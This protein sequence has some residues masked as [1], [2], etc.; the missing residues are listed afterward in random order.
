MCK[1]E[2]ETLPYLGRKEVHNGDS[3][4]HVVPDTRLIDQDSNDLR[5]SQ[6]ENKVYIADFF[7]TS[8]PSICPKVTKQML[9]IYDKYKDDDRVVLI[10]HTIDQRHD[11]VSVLHR[12]AQNLGV[13]TDRWKFVTGEKDSIF[14]LADQY[15]VSV[16][17]DPSAPM[18][19]DHS[20]R[21]I[22]LDKERHVR[23]FCEGTDPESVTAFMETV[24]LLLDEQY[25]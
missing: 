10:S 22:L 25:P 5:I 2:P 21:I 8:C 15:F 24:D 12:Y 4:Y 20:G 19:F 1:N 7:F 6:L 23:G 13:D 16:V 9:R 17:E 14:N 3:V 18:G 11:S